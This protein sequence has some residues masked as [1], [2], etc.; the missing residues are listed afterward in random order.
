MRSNPIKLTTMGF[1]LEL[2][3]STTKPI[4]YIEALYISRDD[5]RFFW[6]WDDITLFSILPIHMITELL[7]ARTQLLVRYNTNPRSWLNT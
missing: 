6:G 7:E 2:E 3:I 5:F 1:C 4:V